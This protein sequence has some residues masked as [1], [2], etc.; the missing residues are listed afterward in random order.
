MKRVADFLRIRE[1]IDSKVTMILGAAA[2]FL[3]LDKAD[4]VDWFTVLIVYFLFLSMFM[5]LSY[6]FNDY[7]D[8]ETDKRAGKTKVIASVPKRLVYVSFAAMILVGDVPVLMLV[9]K[10]LLCLC[11]IVLITMFGLA[12]SLPGIRFKERGALGLVECSFAQRCFPLVLIL[13]F[14]DFNKTNLIMWMIWFVLSFVDGLRYI[15]IHQYIDQENDRNTG[16]HTFVLDKQVNIRRT[17]VC[18]C[19]LEILAC[20]ILLIPLTME[21]PVI[22][23]V[24]MVICALLEFCIYKVL[25]VFAKKD[26]MVSFDSVP[27]EAFFNIIMPVMVGI[28]M[29]KINA[30]AGIFVVFILACC[31]RAIK[32]KKDIVAVYID[33]RISV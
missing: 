22:V 20:T 27:L 5:A 28:C 15:L 17:I 1:W 4:I 6:V 19:L 3:C 16:T 31:V 14:M 9:E 8:L 33:S 10:K 23:A 2:Y 32:A 13:F 24:G 26:W 18:L 21:Y 11:M 29:M 25:N 30:W 7:T 12:Y